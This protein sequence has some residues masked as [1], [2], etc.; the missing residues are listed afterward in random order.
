M[1][2]IQ[3]K[4]TSDPYL[5]VEVKTEPDALCQAC[6]HLG[7]NGC[8]QKDSFSEARV[9][10]RDA[11]ALEALRLTRGEVLPWKR[12]L[13]RISQ[14]LDPHAMEEVCR[15]CRWLPLGYC[16]EGVGAL[17]SSGPEATAREHPQ[18]AR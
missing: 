12:V 9:T 10:G 6:P 7:P 11:R 15:D 14:H 3:M 4:L 18:L 1:S 5:A 13:E 8:R 2:Q 16:V 17:Q